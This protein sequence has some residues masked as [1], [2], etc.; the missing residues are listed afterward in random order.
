MALRTVNLAIELESLAFA[1]KVLNA[2]PSPDSKKGG[3]TLRGR[4]ATE[5][6]AG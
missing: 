4:S 6:E 1:I 5:R 3:P 2:R